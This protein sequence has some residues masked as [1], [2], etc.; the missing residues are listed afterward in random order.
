MH[1][2]ALSLARVG[3][4]T[5]LPG[6]GTVTLPH[7]QPAFLRMW[8]PA[9]LAGHS[10]GG[11]SAAFLTELAR[12]WCRLFRTCRQQALPSR[13]SATARPLLP[14]TRYGRC[15]AS[16]NAGNGINGR[17]QGM[18]GVRLSEDKIS[19]RRALFTV[20]SAAAA[21]VLVAG[22]ADASI[23]GA[24]GLITACYSQATGSVRVINA[25]AGAKCESNEK[26]LTWNQTGP[27]GPQGQRGLPGFDGT[28]GK[29]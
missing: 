9:G 5:A 10:R 18:R 19:S 15:A 20:T 24:G 6:L 14:P 25:E 23:P 4:H 8:T 21:L 16:C 13:P 29:T 26:K 12:R 28:N 17:D 7:M 22:A 27:T 3:A 1:D 11:I 2:R